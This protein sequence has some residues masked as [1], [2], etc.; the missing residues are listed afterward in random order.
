MVYLLSCNSAEIFLFIGAVSLNLDLPFTV[1]Q[2]LWANIIADI[3]PAM[4][5]GGNIF[6][7]S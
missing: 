1:M 7:Y 4:S 2:I 5:L 6:D 3:P